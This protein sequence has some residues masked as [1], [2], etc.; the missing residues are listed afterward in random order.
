MI[1]QE[2]QTTLT[3]AVEEAHRRRHEYITLEHLLF[4]ML[5]EET[6]SDI[7]RQCGGN[8]AQLRRELEEFFQ[9]T[10][11]AL[12]D[13]AEYAVEQTAGFER[14]LDRAFQHALSSSQTRLDSGHLLAALFSEPH[15]H[16][17]Y[18]LEKQGITR[19]DILNYISHGIAKLSDDPFLPDFDV[20]RDGLEGLDDD[21]DDDERPGRDPLAAF[22]V[23][24]VARAAEGK[25]DRLVG[26]AAELERMVH[27]LC[28]RRK[29]NPIL[30]GDPGV[31]KT[32]IVEGLALRIHQGD[33]PDLLKTA[34]IY[35]LDMGALL[36]GT[37]YRGQFEERLKA[38]M[39]ALMKRTNVILFIDEIHTIVGA[40]AVSGGAMD[41]SN[42][43]KPALGSGELRCIGSTTYNEYKQAFER[44]RALARRFQKIEISEPTLE[45]SV[46]ILH[47]LRDYYEAYHGVR[48]ADDALRAA[49]ELSAKHIHDRFLPDK[50][51]DVIDEAGAAVRLLPA[52][53]RPT[54]IGTH[55]IEGVVARMAKVPP[56]TV[57]ASDKD[58]LQ[59]LEPELKAVIYG[60]D[61][62]VEQIVNMVKLARSGLGHPDKPIGSLLFSGPTGVGKTELAKQLARVLGVEFIRFDMSEYMEKHTVSRLIG[63]PPGYVGFDQGG[64]L[65][66][67]VTRTP[68]AVLVLDEIE[69]AHPDL[70]NIL[71]QVM[72]H[73]SLT[74]HNGK[75]A[76]FRNVIMI[77]TTNA[78]AREMSSRQMG[79]GVDSLPMPPTL[80]KAS[81][82]T[83]TD[84]GGIA[85]QRGLS[86]TAA[87]ARQAIEQ[88]FSPEFRNRL[89]AWVVFEPLSFE[90]IEKVVD[91]FIGELQAQ[92]DEKRV[93]VDL[94]PT[95][96]AWLAQ[97]GFDRLFGARP[98]ARLIQEKIKA[99]LANEILFGALQ[100]GGTVHVETDG[101]DL[102]LRYT[103]SS[104]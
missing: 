93:T 19:L 81:A 102:K 22:T 20:D 54:V 28:R 33:V 8:V 90:V 56:K 10:L 46:S 99:P 25:I 67:A 47:G 62:A 64:L 49:V 85:G 15:S 75:K 30:V 23:N 57:S 58:R 68:Y 97:R 38:V 80:T 7:L 78:G 51:I 36:A 12:P 43:L 24:L 103:T 70:F 26:R 48:F 60:Q 13:D 6:A 87:K 77:M 92:L 37:K 83:P 84:G 72:D 2:L 34:E 52:D 91:K 55:E 9:D 18:L 17:R 79:F 41:A 73:A 65:T 86:P 63:A 69:K 39:A 14:V 16:A 89:D 44:D 66:D 59:Q 32:A 94:S 45:D 5:E 104:Q 31:G 50:A 3:R 76:D 53:Q 82:L 74:D 4:A 61:H 101:D 11:E 100:G 27:V 88:T 96:R 35:L 40:G 95:S 29:N 98:M 71:L 21:E 1:T 42:I